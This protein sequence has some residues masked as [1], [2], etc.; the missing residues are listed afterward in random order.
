MFYYTEDKIKNCAYECPS[1]YKFISEKKECLKTC[2]SNMTQKI[3]DSITKCYDS[4]DTLID[5]AEE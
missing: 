1:D 2:D 5:G 4:R 3:N